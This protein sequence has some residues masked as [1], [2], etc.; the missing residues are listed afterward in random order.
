MTDQGVTDQVANVIIRRMQA[1]DQQAWL[2]LWA[3][4]NTFYKRSVTDPATNRTWISLLAGNGEPFGYVAELD[5]K[6]VGFAHYF[7]TISTSDDGPRCYLQDLFA[8]PS[9]RGKGIGRALIQAVYEDADQ[10]NASQTYWLT[11]EDN[12]TARKLYDAVATKTPF[13]KYAR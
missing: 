11:A 12:H 6:V 7:M 10:H 1:T 3:G 9:V 8:D 4:Y 2:D 5:G 13:I